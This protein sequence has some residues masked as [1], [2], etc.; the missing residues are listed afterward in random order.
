VRNM[1]SIFKK[2]AQRMQGSSARCH[3]LPCQLPQLPL[4]AL[5]AAAPRP[6]IAFL[7]VHPTRPHLLSSLTRNGATRQACRVGRGS[8][9]SLRHA[10]ARAR[11]RRLL[12]ICEPS[13]SEVP[14]G[15]DANYRARWPALETGHGRRQVEG[16]AARGKYKC[17]ALR[18][19]I[20]KVYGLLQQ[21]S[22]RPRAKRSDEKEGMP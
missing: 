9:S 19:G 12:H 7:V 8:G 5:P 15:I 17:L 3:A 22:K 21:Y 20:T 4:L 13:V 6:I 10:A 18:P 2:Q 14:G 11:Q 1:L 16:D